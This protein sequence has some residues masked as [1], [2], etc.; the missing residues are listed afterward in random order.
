MWFDDNLTYLLQ[1]TPR[2]DSM[3]ISRMR[4]SIYVPIQAYNQAFAT[5]VANG[6]HSQKRGAIWIKDSAKRKGKN[7][8]WDCT[9][10]TVLQSRQSKSREVECNTKQFTGFPKTTLL[11]A[12]SSQPRQI[13]MRWLYICPQAN[14][15]VGEGNLG[16]LELSSIVGSL[17]DDGRVQIVHSFPGGEL[18]LSCTRYEVCWHKVPLN[19]DWGCEGSR[20][21]WWK[22]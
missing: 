22:Q 2:R 10:H 6:N 21:E 5:S 13:E 12:G 7:L 3:P 16:N 11:A 19:Q 4:N 20:R 18:F 1:D 9:K 15:V 17:G 8:P 14:F